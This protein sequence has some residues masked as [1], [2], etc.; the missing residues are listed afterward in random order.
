MATSSACGHDKQ[1]LDT[2]CLTV[3]LASLRATCF[4]L[5]Q[6]PNETQVRLRVIKYILSLKLTIY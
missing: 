5:P 3:V 6:Q 2:V 1:C 4:R